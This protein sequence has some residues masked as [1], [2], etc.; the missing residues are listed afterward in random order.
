MNWMLRT[1]NFNV[2]LTNLSVV[3]PA[4]PKRCTGH[5]VTFVYTVLE[6]WNTLKITFKYLRITKTYPAFKALHSYL[7]MD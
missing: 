6:L 7:A 3:L 5:K 1:F 2:F 4:T